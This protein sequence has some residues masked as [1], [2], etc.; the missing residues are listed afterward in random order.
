MYQQSQQRARA[1]S[2]SVG[3]SKPVGRE[4]APDSNAPNNIEAVFDMEGHRLPDIIHNKAYQIAPCVDYQGNSNEVGAQ[5]IAPAKASV[6]FLG[7][8]ERRAQYIAPLL[9]CYNTLYFKML[10]LFE[11]HC[12]ILRPYLAAE[13]SVFCP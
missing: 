6:T 10:L 7:A 3:N 4:A 13:K 2:S 11:P 5:Y 12:N 9:R 1:S 8:L